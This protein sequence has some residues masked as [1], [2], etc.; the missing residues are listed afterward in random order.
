MGAILRLLTTPAPRRILALAA[1]LSTA[2]VWAGP[3]QASQTHQ[4]TKSFSPAGGFGF[5]LG[6]AINQSTEEVYV[7]DYNNGTV[8]AFEAS[9]APDPV[10]P[11]LIKAPPATEPF[12]MANPYGVAVDNSA[13]PTHGDVYVAQAG[14]GAVDQFNPSGARTS[15]API[16][17][18]DMPAEGT[19]QSGGLPNV[20]NGGGFLPTGLAVTS[21]GDIYVADQANNVVDLFEP[22]GTFISQLAAGDISGPNLIAVDASGRP[23]RRPERLRSARVQPRRHLPQLLH[24]DRPRRQPRRRDQPRR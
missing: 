20:V 3:A 12:P 21:E 17:V 2:C 15:Q 13:Q 4:F 8:Y 16:T 18:A 11:R 5:P 9:G 22:N 10:H 6:V 14:G 7:S 24:A 23:L 1:L 19:A